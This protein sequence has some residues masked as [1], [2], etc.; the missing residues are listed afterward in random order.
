MAELGEIIDTNLNDGQDAVNNVVPEVQLHANIEPQ[1]PLGV[2]A[3]DPIAEM[4]DMDAKAI[5][6][7]IRNELIVPL[8]LSLLIMAV[9]W[10]MLLHGSPY[11]FPVGAVFIFIAS[12]TC[13]KDIAGPLP[14]SVRRSDLQ[15]LEMRLVCTWTQ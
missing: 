14:P 13:A 1:P 15:L 8:R 5:A 4:S 2:L 11:V 7:F 3:N 9:F 6:N 10:S 12:I